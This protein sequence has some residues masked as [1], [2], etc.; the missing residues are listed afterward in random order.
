MKGHEYRNNL[1]S[2]AE[3]EEEMNRSRKAST[4]PS[5][6]GRENVCPKCRV[7]LGALHKPGC[8][9][10]PCPYCYGPLGFCFCDDPWE[11]D[12]PDSDRVVWTGDL[13]YCANWLADTGG[14]D[15]NRLRREVR[16]D[17]TKKQWV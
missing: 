16:W 6:A 12:V 1:D 5:D 15:L 3:E 11:L 4:K 14:P 7:A 13:D 17:Q 9:L 10:E 2:S 8:C